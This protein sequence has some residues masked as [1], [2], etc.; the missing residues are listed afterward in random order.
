MSVSNEGCAAEDMFGRGAA[1][2]PSTC[3][4]VAQAM[5]GGMPALVINSIDPF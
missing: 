1:S 2:V 3:G 4:K 5:V